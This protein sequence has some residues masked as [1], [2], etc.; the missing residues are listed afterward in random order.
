MLIVVFSLW[1]ALVSFGL[2]MWVIRKVIL[3]KSALQQRLLALQDI[4]N[5][6]EKAQNGLLTL[7]DIPFVERVIKPLENYIATQINQL[8]PQRVRKYLEHRLVVAGKGEECSA[9]QF[10]GLC[11]TSMI[12]TMMLMVMIL[13]GGQ[14]LFIQKLVFILGGGL[15][16]G[17]MPVVCLNV[18]VQKRQAEI[19][20][21]L[22]DVLDLLC[23]SVQAGFSFDASLRQITTRMQGAFIDECKRLQY[24]IRMGMERRIA[25][26]N[27]A[28]RC[29]VQDVALFMTSIIQAESLGTSMGRVL[30]DQADNIR[31]R[32]RQYV[33]AEAMRAPV[34]ILFPLIFF[35]FPAV[36]V[37]VLVPT[38][39]ALMK[40]M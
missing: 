31:D 35:I 24:D 2:C 39:L 25:M 38:L 27:M 36:F 33:K 12:L 28:E 22:P 11:L 18:T 4:Q 40:S 14:Y 5:Q 1:I 16:G 15:L 9:P 10:I 29:E 19:S 32:R 7:K 3:P 20:R 13:D 6:E 34:K 17:L 8:T 37:V 23:V 30:K 21:Q 26:K